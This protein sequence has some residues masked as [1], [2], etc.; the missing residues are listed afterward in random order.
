[1][2]TNTPLDLGEALTFEFL[3]GL[4]NAIKWPKIIKVPTSKNKIDGQFHQKIDS[5]FP[6][7]DQTVSHF[8]ESFILNPPVPSSQN[9]HKHYITLS[10]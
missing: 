2:K 4:S 5:Q 6:R 3:V 9:L 7:D 10:S 1:M 8:H